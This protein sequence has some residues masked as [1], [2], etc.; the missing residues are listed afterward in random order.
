M[1]GAGISRATM[2]DRPP[3]RILDI[4]RLVARADGGPLT[5]IDR[6]ERAYLKGLIAAHAPFY[7]ASRA[8]LGWLMI[9]GADA[10]KV[11]GWIDNVA[12]LPAP[13][14]A[15]RLLSGPRRT[16]ALEAALREIAVARLRP[17][18]LTGWLK[19]RAEGN[20]SWISVGHMNLADRTLKSARK[21]GLKTAVMLHDAIPLDHPNWSATGAT[22]RFAA[23]LDGVALQADIIFCPSQ[24]AARRLAL[25]MQPEGKVLIAPLGVESAEADPALIPASFRPDHASFVCLG[26]IEPRK[27][28]GLLFNVW[29]QLQAHLPVTSVPHLH[30][31]G[32]RGWGS[33]ALLGHLARSSL[34]GRCIFQHTGLPDAAVA[35]MLLKSRALL[36]PSRAEGFGFPPAEAA[37]MGVPVIATDL[38][39]TQEVIGHYATYLP[40]DDPQAWVEAILP[41]SAPGNR[42]APL[43]LPDWTAHFNLVFN[44]V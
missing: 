1:P 28:I 38:S 26:T 10:R 4:T 34:H 44:H 29:T 7:L 6:V 2:T 13:G 21:A 31:V 9:D 37:A 22:E 16:P 12:S 30:L 11:L 36:A 14:L 23:A 3:L 42:R 32:R 40:P 8:A 43:A 27:N 25:H 19:R 18:A 41:L 33:D 15:G 17:G 39:V 5:G 35:A 24:S 20:G